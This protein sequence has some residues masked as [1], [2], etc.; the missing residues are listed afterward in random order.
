VSIQ[1]WIQAAEVAPE[2]TAADFALSEDTVRRLRASTSRNTL[3]AYRRAWDGTRTGS[4][5]ADVDQWITPDPPGGFVGW[6]LEEKRVA[7]PATE[8]TLAEY[9]AHLAD[10]DFAVSTIQQTIYAIRTVHRWSGHKRQPDTEL[11]LALLKE[12]SRDRAKRGKGR[13]KAAAPITIEELHLMIATCDPTTLL[14]LRDWLLMVLALAMFGRESEV[15]ALN[16]DDVEIIDGGIMVYVGSSKTDQA[17]RGE[18]VRIRSDSFDETDLPA[19][20]RAWK[21]MLALHGVIG[22]PLIR[23]VPYDRPGERLSGEWVGRVFRYRAQQAGLE[24]ADQVS[25]HTARAAAFTIGCRNKV[26]HSVLLRMG[27]LSPRSNRLN[28]YNRAVDDM[29]HNA[30]TGVL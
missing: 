2:Y 5:D 28:V 25:G 4:K 8:Y 19:L 10:E 6:C 18:E 29:E 13:Q 20:L 15:V 7:L 9:V 21:A 3:R 12:H 16:W 11:A 27:R 22:G 26:P 30:W 24:H 23:A 14:G 1:P 17:A